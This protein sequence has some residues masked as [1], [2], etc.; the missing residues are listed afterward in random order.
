MHSVAPLTDDKRFERE[1]VPGLLSPESF[2]IA[3][4][5]YQAWVLNKLNQQIAGTCQPGLPPPNAAHPIVPLFMGCVGS[6]RGAVPASVDGI[7]D[8]S[9]HQQA[10]Q[11]PAIS[12]RHPV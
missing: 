1:G 4:T 3:Y 9:L 2:D 6:H 10:D 5:T 11:A 12:S 7:A 8:H